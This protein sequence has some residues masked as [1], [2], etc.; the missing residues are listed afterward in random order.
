MLVKMCHLNAIFMTSLLKTMLS[1]SMIK[2]KQLVGVFFNI[3]FIKFIK[4][5]LAYNQECKQR[6]ILPLR[7]L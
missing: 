4:L 7:V 1:K 6:N 3:L 5:H 2:I